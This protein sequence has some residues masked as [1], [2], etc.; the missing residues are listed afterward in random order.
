MINEISAGVV[1]PHMGG[2]KVV[3]IHI[4]SGRIMIMTI[5]IIITIILPPMQLVMTHIKS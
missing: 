5:T 4:I 1:M 2:R 3:T